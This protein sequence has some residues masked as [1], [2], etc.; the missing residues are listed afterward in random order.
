M[1]TTSAIGVSWITQVLYA[2][3]FITRYQNFFAEQILW[4]FLFKTFYVA[5]SIYIIAIMRWRY[6]RTRE[7]EVAWKLGA[8]VLVGS[9]VISPFAMMI[10]EE[11]WSFFTVSFKENSLAPF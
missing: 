4:N 3:V 11:Y 9:L 2:V 1:L 5:S 7:R 6:P 10:G 8:A